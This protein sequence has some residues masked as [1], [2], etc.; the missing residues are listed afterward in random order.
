MQVSRTRAF[1]LAAAALA[2]GG[3]T[4]LTHRVT[5]PAPT[6]WRQAVTVSYITVPIGDDML[7]YQGQ[8]SV[9]EEMCLAATPPPAIALDLDPART[10]PTTIRY[11]RR[12]G[13]CSTPPGEM[14]EPGVCWRSTRPLGNQRWACPGVSPLPTARRPAVCE[15][16]AG[17]ANASSAPSRRQRARWGCRADLGPE[18]ARWWS[19]PG[20]AAQRYLTAGAERQSQVF[21]LDAATG[22]ERWA[23]DLTGTDL[24]S[25]FVA[26]DGRVYYFTFDGTAVA[27][28]AATGQQL[29]ATPLGHTEPNDPHSEPVYADGNSLATGDGT[30]YALDAATG[31]KLVG[32][33]GEASAPPGGQWAVRAARRPRGA[34][35][36]HRRAQLGAAHRCA[37]LPD[38]EYYPSIDTEPRSAAAWPTS[39]SAT[40]CRAAVTP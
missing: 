26:G 3:A 28:E 8:S 33:A 11:R 12:P 20:I 40:S 35:R 17:A 16:D 19:T 14:A 31:E 27:L 15:T 1:A 29:W 25:R 21:A 37:G 10:P 22:E 39:S 23:F 34:G 7:I 36:G 4:C 2:C 5:L 18:R 24:Q 6:Q 32:A 9:L 13:L 30:A 38:M